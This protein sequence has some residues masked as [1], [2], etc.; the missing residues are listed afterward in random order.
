MVIRTFWE[1]EERKDKHTFRRE[2]RDRGAGS[3]MII[4]KEL[5]KVS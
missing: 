2:N 1:G 4:K 3:E 5:V